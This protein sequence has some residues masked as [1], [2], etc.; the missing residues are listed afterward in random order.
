MKIVGRKNIAAHYGVQSRVVSN[1]VNRQGAPSTYEIDADNHVA[2]VIETEEI[3][4]W[5]LNKEHKPSRN[6]YS[7][8][9]AEKNAAQSNEEDQPSQ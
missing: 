2:V 4:K 5:L 1:W 8:H 6:R 7:K 9:L 3:D